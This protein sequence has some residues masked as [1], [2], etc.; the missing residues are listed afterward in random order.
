MNFNKRK[1]Q[2]FLLTLI[3]VFSL[4]SFSGL[5]LSNNKSLE[6]NAWD[7]ITSAEELQGLGTEEDPYLISTPEELFWLSN[8][9]NQ[10]LIEASDYFELTANINLGGYEWTPIGD[11]N[12]GDATTAFR[13]NF[14]GAEYII[15][16]FKLEDSQNIN[17]YSGLFGYLSSA[18]IKNLKIRQFSIDLDLT[19]LGDALYAGL[20]AGYSLDSNI[21]NISNAPNYSDTSYSSI[22]IINSAEP[23]FL[24]GILGYAESSDLSEI[25]SRASI[26]TSSVN[27]VYA[28][29]LVGRG[30]NITIEKSYNKGVVTANATAQ[31]YVGGLVAMT[32]ETSFEKV[33][34]SGNIT[35]TADA[36]AVGG[37]AGILSGGEGE[38]IYTTKFAYNVGRVTLIGLDELETELYLGGLFGKVEENNIITYVYNASEVLVDELA[39]DEGIDVENQGTLIGILELGAE[40][41]NAYYDSTLANVGLLGMGVIDGEIGGSVS[42]TSTANMKVASTFEGDDWNLNSSNS[43]W[44]ISGYVN[45]RYPILKNI[46]NYLV[47][48]QVSGQGTLTPAA[49][50]HYYELGSGRTY[51]VK[52]SA[53]YQIK[54]ITDDTGVLSQFSGKYNAV[55]NVNSGG[56][57]VGDSFTL[58]VVFEPIPFTKTQMF[59]WLIGVGSLIIIMIVGTAII[60]YRYAIKMDKIMSEKKKSLNI[61]PSKDKDKK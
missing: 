53:G 42:P 43:V 24:G 58:E 16:N 5:I 50:M 39:S 33:F 11:F 56:L 14:D 23:I 35:A 38:D 21:N 59:Y 32:S 26:S 1:K 44:A 25:E 45:N 29:G 4:A 31:A 3:I 61:E 57:V 12:S 60:N 13:G 48:A 52:A 47:H 22:Q 34:N 28:G 46:G 7:G 41:D 30:E 6:V 15:Y 10:G 27:S 8:Q 9:T 36:V 19:T 40:F 55:V 18:T 2:L 54:Q 51:N 17:N 20:L 49:G 37:L